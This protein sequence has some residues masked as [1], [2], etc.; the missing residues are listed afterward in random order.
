MTA[1]RDI[2][3]LDGSIGQELVKRAGGTPTPLWSTQAMRDRPDLLAALHRDYIA[4]GATVVST[5][6]YPMHRSRLEPAGLMAELPA[7]QTVALD[8]AEAARGDRADIRIAATIGPL[9]ASYRPDLDPPEAEAAAS[10]REIAA[11]LAPRADLLL[12]ETVSSRR[13]GR[14][15]MAGLSGL[16]RPVWLAYTVED[17]DGT[18]LRSGEPLAEV[19]DDLE[20]LG[21]E[22]EAVLINCSR[23]EA[24]TQA[25]P[26]LT[27]QPRPVGAYA[28]GFT[29]IT[30]AFRKRGATVT[31]LQAR[32]DLGP[33]DY[34]EHA[35]R[36]V[37]DGAT[38]VG[39]CCE[40]GPAHIAELARAL[41]DAGHP[42]V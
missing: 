32:H 4:A 9:M 28:N 27:A 40:V 12:V 10:F 26:I 33:P 2:T 31:A 15:A 18:R 25:V 21:D 39:G 42:I 5:N 41:R 3:L 36:W 17:E 23:P 38:I 35:M 29:R 30:E 20:A 24:V 6:T 14:A 8:A 13:E 37:A 16:G 22:V 7:L 34:A 11:P 1:A 19:L